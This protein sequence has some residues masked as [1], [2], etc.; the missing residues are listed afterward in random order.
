MKDKIL[1][2]IFY[3]LSIY[4]VLFM[5]FSFFYGCYGLSELFTDTL[6]IKLP[7][8]LFFI[9]GFCS[10]GAFVATIQVEIEKNNEKKQ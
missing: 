5:I 3:A 9:M 2:W 1:N 10:L 4:F 8:V 7:P 6:N